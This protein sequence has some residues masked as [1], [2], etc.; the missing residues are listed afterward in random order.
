MHP[1]P[2]HYEISMQVRP[3]KTAKL[4]S[5]ELPQIESAP[6]VE[7]GGPGDR[8]SPEGLFTA[9][10]ADCI[11]LNFQ[12]IAAMSKFSWTSL[13]GKTKAVLDRTDGKLRFTRFDTHIALTIPAGADPA[14]AKLLLEKAET[15]CPLS[16]TLNC[17][18]HLTMEITTA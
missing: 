13:E 16:N 7:F 2:H 10:I 8:W 18:K 15:S 4:T 6:P 9:A 1:F 17:E 5:G 14:R 3:G 11:I 12:G